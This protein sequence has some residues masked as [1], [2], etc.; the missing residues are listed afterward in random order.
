MSV[1]RGFKYRIYPTPNQRQ[2]LT[3]WFGSC[4]FVWN[5]LHV[6]ST[7]ISALDL[8]KHLVPL[9][10]QFPWLAETPSQALQ[11]A[12]LNLGQARTRQRRKLGSGPRKKRRHDKQSL[13]LPQGVSV[14]EW[15]G[16]T[17]RQH[18]SQV[19]VCHPKNR[20]LSLWVPKMA[21]P[22]KLV[23]HRPLPSLALS[24]TISKDAD[25]SYWASFVCEVE[26]KST[27][28]FEMEAAQ[29]EVGIDVGFKDIAADSN[30]LK[31]PAPQFLRKSEQKLKRL[32]RNLSRKTKGSNRWRLAL[33]KLQQL[34][35]KIRYQRHDFLDKLSRDYVRENQ[36][37]VVEGIRF[38]KFG[39][40]GGGR[41]SASDAGFGMLRKMLGYKATE[42]GCDFRQLD[43]WKP[44]TGVCPNTL[45]PRKTKLQLHE[46]TWTCECCN[47]AWDRDIAS[48]V[49]I[50]KLGKDVAHLKRVVS[51]KKTL[52]ISQLSASR[53]GK[54]A[55]ISESL[56]ACQNYC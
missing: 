36:A 25:E 48:A 19:T 30:G 22:M 54:E 27:H 12:V 42:E 9:K 43:P 40:G 28:D 16:E 13:T 33:A 1:I 8:K 7:S 35:T 14:S 49:V 18:L 53:K 5:Q 31:V 32:Q 26:I 55:V 41:K 17:R 11:S 23:Y 37:V 6:D 20:Y 47:I 39:L 44:T 46:R 50:L 4:R 10:H 52:C 21:T 29:P 24:V 45:I 51:A 38:V 3:R 34:H 56:M 2:T 15:H